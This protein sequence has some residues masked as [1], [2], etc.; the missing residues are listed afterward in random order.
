MNEKNKALFIHL[1]EPKSFAQSGDQ[2][3]SSLLE[4]LSFLFGKHGSNYK[5]II[6]GC[7]NFAPLMIQTLA[8]P[9]QH[10]QDQY[11]Y[12]S[13]Q[14]FASDLSILL[15]KKGLPIYVDTPRHAPESMS[16][17]VDPEVPA[18]IVGSLKVGEEPDEAA[19]TV[20]EQL[21]ASGLETTLLFLSL[22]P[23]LTE[24]NL[25][26]RLLPILKQYQGIPGEE[27]NV[28]QSIQDSAIQKLTLMSLFP[29]MWI[30]SL[31]DLSGIDTLLSGN[32]PQSGMLI[33][34]KQANSLHSS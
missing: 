17:I 9:T 32:Q 6:L 16:Y 20:T 12:H 23:N 13:R 5:K 19:A 30:G 14:H 28:L 21:Q 31:S 27:E 26:I 24:Q 33:T 2:T 18:F 34:R 10:A 15:N 4:L 11:L 3:E 7:G 25:D 29:Q 8:A 22:L 1:T